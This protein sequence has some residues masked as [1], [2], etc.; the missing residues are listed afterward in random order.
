MLDRRRMLEPF[1]FVA[2]SVCA[3]LGVYLSGF[4]L[5]C[6]DRGP[7]DG[8]IGHK[9]PWVFY[10]PLGDSYWPLYMRMQSWL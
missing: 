10:G 9:A 4:V 5:F 1:V 6:F 2:A 7:L 8:F 3:L